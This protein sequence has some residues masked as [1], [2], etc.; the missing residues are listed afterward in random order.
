MKN[1][2]LTAIVLFSVSTV[3]ALSTV[4]PSGGVRAEGYV[5]GSTVQISWND[6]LT[7]NAIN[8]GLWNGDTG[9]LTQLAQGVDVSLGSYDWAIPAD[10]PAG[11]RYRFVITDASNPRKLELSG[12]W[13]SLGTVGALISSISEVD[14][15]EDVQCDPFPA[16]TSVR[17]SWK[18]RIVTTVEIIDIMHR[19]VLKRDVDSRAGSIRLDIRDLASGLVFVRLRGSNGSL[20]ATPLMINH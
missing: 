10:Q 8:V 17:V 3:S 16:S 14:L 5:N 20:V 4:F 15:G 2:V 13:I 9:M 12:G 6:D 19:V 7:A 1:K 11:S 18:D